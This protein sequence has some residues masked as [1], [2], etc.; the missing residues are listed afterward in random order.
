MVDIQRFDIF[1]IDPPWPKKKGGKRSVRPN[2]DRFLEYQTMQIEAIFDLLD[3]HI[4]P[5]ANYEHSVFLWLVD[6]FLHDGEMEMQS[7]GY[8]RH[9]RFIWDKGNGVAPAFS[10]RFSH[11]Y[12]TWFYKPTFK[13]IDASIRG[14]WTTV[15]RESS[16]EHSR[17][18]QIAY[19]MISSFYPNMSKLDVFSREFHHGWQQFGNE[20]NYFH[21]SNQIKLF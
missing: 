8:K 3:K 6:E 10:V 4:F 7:R 18:P 9:A 14:K 1:M 13:K 5:L 2:Q 19:D 16:R 12:M 15:F 11:E 17:K 21:S 20:I